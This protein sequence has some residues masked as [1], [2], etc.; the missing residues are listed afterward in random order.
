MSVAGRSAPSSVWVRALFWQRED[1][2]KELT[3]E[4]CLISG[5]YCTRAINR[6]FSTSSAAIILFSLLLFALA[7]SSGCPLTRAGHG[8][9][10]R[11]LPGRPSAPSSPIERGSG[12]SNAWVLSSHL[13]VVGK[14]GLMSSTA[15]L[16]KPKG[17]LPVSL[18]VLAQAVSSANSCVT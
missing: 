13:A 17:P 6:S 11:C 5:V 2:P 15:L 1:A 9:S 18:K 3:G 4:G 14:L 12:F 7:T 16:L 8:F 10:Y